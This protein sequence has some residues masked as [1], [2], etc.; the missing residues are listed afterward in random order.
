[1][2]NSR[3][4]G[5]T[6]LAILTALGGLV[7]LY[8]TLQYLHILPFYLGQMAFYGFDFWGAL[9]WGLSTLAYAWATVMLWQMNPQGWMFATLL[10]GLNL[11][12]DIISLI[13]ASSLQA[14]LPSIIIN[15]AVLIYC[16][17]PSTREAF[18]QA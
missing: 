10:S 17:V 5:V 9:L 18:A 11:I 4:F 8:H 1:V 6:I 2:T 14:L 7:A 3:P 12:L 13:G 16:L 15:A